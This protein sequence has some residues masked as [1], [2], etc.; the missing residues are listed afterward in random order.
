MPFSQTFTGDRADR[1]LP[2]KL[3]TPN[4]RS[5]MLSILVAEAQAWYRGGLLESE[6]M[7]AAKDAYI[8]ANDFISE[9]VNEFC[10]FG[11]GFIELREFTETLRDNSD[12]ARKTP[13]RILKDMVKKWL[14]GKNGVTFKKSTDN[15]SRRVGF[16]GI[17]WL[18]GG[19]PAEAPPWD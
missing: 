10:E 15:K 5:A 16:S 2:E 19:R 11:D 13:E 17:R 9:F 8:A 7:V 12:E 14:I 6:E 18:D 1:Q 4:A 3:A